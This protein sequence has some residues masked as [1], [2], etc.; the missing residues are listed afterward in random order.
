MMRNRVAYRRAVD[1]GMSPC[2]LSMGPSSGR[3]V[4]WASSACRP[5]LGLH[6]RVTTSSL[7]IS[8][9]VPEDESVRT[10]VRSKILG[11]G[12]DAHAV[13]RMRRALADDEGVRTQLF[14]PA[15]VARCDRLPDP[16][17][18]YAACF[19][20][21]EAALK[22]LGVTPPD[23]GIFRDAE[24]TSGHHAP[25][26]V[27]AGRLRAEAARLGVTNLHLSIASTTDHVIATVILE[28]ADSRH[29]DL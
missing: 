15:E 12:V 22:A 19:A 16:A 24:V 3:S 6:L 26:L 10:H 23:V 4:K 13:D 29:P 25:I 20:A 18:H 8:T 7:S 11:V 28:H 9:T 17:R 2:R 21:K 1:R 5:S 14:T 27:F